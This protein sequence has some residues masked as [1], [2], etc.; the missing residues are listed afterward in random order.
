VKATT[1]TLGGGK[2]EV[3]FPPGK[4]REKREI[5]TLEPYSAGGG[6]KKNKGISAIWLICRGKG[7]GKKKRG[8]K[9][10]EIPCPAHLA[11]Q[12]KV[13][14]AYSPPAEEEGRRGSSAFT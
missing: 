10:R 4:E 5:D 2:L 3:N 8:G 11:I 14:V 9:K 12:K 13:S 7:E 6:K 1:T